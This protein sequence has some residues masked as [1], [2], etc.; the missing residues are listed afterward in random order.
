MASDALSAAC[1][2]GAGAAAAFSSS[3]ERKKASKRTCGTRQR[4]PAGCV[5]SV[6]SRGAFSPSGQLSSDFKGCST[7][8]T[9]S[10][11]AAPRFS[12]LSTS[13]AISASSRSSCVSS[14]SSCWNGCLATSTS[15]PAASA[16]PTTP[17]ASALRCARSRALV[18]PN[19]EEKV[20]CDFLSFSAA[21]DSTAASRS[22]RSASSRRCITSI[23]FRKSALTD[24][25][26]ARTTP[27]DAAQAVRRC[28]RPRFTRDRRPNRSDRTGR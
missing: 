15:W 7:R 25:G 3:K 8:S 5:P 1:F 17:S 28:S 2:F 4:R 18:E 16:W 27:R 22:K 23:D 19:M 12:R 11:S 24:V 10:S 9:S 14:A 20:D 6:K 13:K 26:S 21:L